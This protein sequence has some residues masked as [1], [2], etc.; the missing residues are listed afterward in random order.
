MIDLHNHILPG[1][2]DGAADLDESL[3]IARR[4]VSEGVEVAAATPHLDP[5]NGRG[6]QPNVIEDALISLRTALADEG[7]PLEVLQGNELF[8]TPEAPS[9]LASG[10]ALC[11]G[12]SRAVLVEVSLGAAERPLYLDD[13]LHQLQVGGYTPI[14]A[15][16]ERYPFVVRDPSVIDG[17]ADRGIP[18]QLTAPSLLG[19]Y[20]SPIRRTAERLLEL[21]R[22]ALGASDRHRAKQTRSLSDMYRRIAELADDQTADLLLRT[23]PKRILQD[24]E[25]IPPEARPRRQPGLFERLLGDA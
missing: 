10:R 20:G 15:H 9:L 18:L 14:L 3:E 22:Y 16:P 1:L 23:N 7:V 4:F 13:V 24:Q 8:L 21:G 11:L 5:L 25:P 19:H 6:A 12:K 17:L 2:D